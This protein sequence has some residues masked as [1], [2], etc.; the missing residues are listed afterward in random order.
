MTDTLDAEIEQARRKL[1]E[2]KDQ[3]A[4]WTHEAEIRAVRLD[5]LERA[6]ELRP[7]RGRKSLENGGTKKGR[8]PGAI[9][10]QW[11]QVLLQMAMQHPAGATEQEVVALTKL[12]DG[13]GEIRPKDV[14]ERMRAYAKNNLVRQNLMMTGWQVPDEA[15]AR[16]RTDVVTVDESQVAETETAGAVEAPAAA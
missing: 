5:A 8:K 2:A 11:R 6:A 16:L 15:L 9:S 14:E 10:R 12:V 1:Q 3:A 4:H 13:M 7:V